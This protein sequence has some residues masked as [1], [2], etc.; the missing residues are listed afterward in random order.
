MSELDERAHSKLPAS[1]SVRWLNCAASVALEEKSPPSPDTP[2][3]LEAVHSPTSVTRPS[4]YVF[5]GQRVS[6]RDRR[7]AKDTL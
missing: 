5:R 1:G 4:S 3:S 6:R 7:N 2:W